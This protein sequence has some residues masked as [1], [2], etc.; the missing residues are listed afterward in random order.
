MDLLCD[1]NKTESQTQVIV[2]HAPEVAALCDRII[3][4]ADGLIE[5]EEIA[6][7]IT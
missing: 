1:L 5:R 2:T 6:E 4:M 3:Y 7:Q